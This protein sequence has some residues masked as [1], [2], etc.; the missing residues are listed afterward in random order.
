MAHQ[1]SGIDQNRRAKSNAQRLVVVRPDPVRWEVQH[2]PTRIR[3]NA[4]GHYLDERLAHLEFEQRRFGLG[5]DV[6]TIKPNLR[7]A[8]KFRRM[9]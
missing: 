5:R 8:A 6:Q 2:Q 3:V 7:I 1:V 9:S 4:V